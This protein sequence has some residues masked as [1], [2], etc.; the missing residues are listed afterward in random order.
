MAHE[1]DDYTNLVF[2][3]YTL[4][5]APFF[6]IFKYHSIK[7]PSHDETKFHRLAKQCRFNDTIKHAVSVS[8][9]RMGLNNVSPLDIKAL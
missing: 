3:R 1:C 2:W 9:L 5:F 6:L 8:E 7:R 4:L